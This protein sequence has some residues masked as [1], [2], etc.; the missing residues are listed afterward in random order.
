MP[1]TVVIIWQTH[2]QNVLKELELQGV[3]VT[4]C[5]RMV[6]AF[7]QALHQVNSNFSFKNVP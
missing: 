2:V 5:G 7:G 3:M 1:L 4:V 6:A